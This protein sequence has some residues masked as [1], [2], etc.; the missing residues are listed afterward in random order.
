MSD[1]PET[2]HLENQMGEA[3]RHS[4]PIL[5]EHSR[6]L[7]RERDEARAIIQEAKTKFCCD[8]SDGEIA[9]AM[10]HILCK[11]FSISSLPSVFKP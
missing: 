10:F 4:H 7:E 1:T 9:A 2:D 6:K 5:W 3:S 11:F 8:G